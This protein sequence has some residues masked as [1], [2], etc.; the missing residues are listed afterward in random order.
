LFRFLI[1][2]NELTNP[3]IVYSKRLGGVRQGRREIVRI[4][5]VYEWK[6]EK[7]LEVR[8][9]SKCKESLDIRDLMLFVCYAVV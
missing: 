7:T 9:F 3:E 5:V 6:V 1:I 8:N 4:K 2:P